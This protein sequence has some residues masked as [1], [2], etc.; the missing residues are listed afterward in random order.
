MSLTGVDIIIQLL[1]YF[2]T[3]IISII[4]KHSCDSPWYAFSLH[5]LYIFCPILDCSWFRWAV[6]H[7]SWRH[8]ARCLLSYKSRAFL[9]RLSLPPDL[10]PACCQCDEAAWL[11]VPRPCFFLCFMHP[12]LSAHYA[13][14]SSYAGIFTIDLTDARIPLFSHL[15]VMAIW[16]R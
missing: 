1:Y 8:L 3:N 12:T 14:H 10:A 11:S 9:V 16:V 15:F 5:S 2:L 7:C 4:A 13:L 6:H